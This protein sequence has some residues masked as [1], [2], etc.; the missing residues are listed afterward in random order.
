MMRRARSLNFNAWTISAVVFAAGVLVSATIVLADTASTSVTVG[1]SSPTVS[2]VSMNGGTNITLTE[3]TFVNATT[4]FTVTDGNG[5]STISSVSAQFAFASTSAALYG[6]NCSY[7]AQVCYFPTLCAAT[8]TGNT[9]TGGSD[10]SVQYDCGY[11]IWYPARPTDG[12]SPGLSSAQWYVSATATDA[13]AATGNA[14]NTGE[15]IEVVTLNALNVSGSIGFG[16][17]SANADT[18]G[19]NQSVTHTNTGNTAI[20]NQVSGDVMCTDYSTCVGGVLQ[21]SQQKFGLSDVTYAS[22]TSTLAATTSP[23]SIEFDLATSSAT[24]TAITDL[25][26]WGIAI[27]NGQTTGAYTGQNTFTAVAD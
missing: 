27:P 3:N 14:T 19:T 4:T 10:T 21:P 6:A 13:S 8:T 17:V 16:T 12:S 22:L 1:N 18:G 26:Y 20:D 15:T 25:S 5:C 23:A 24:T 2:A 11:K 9:C 7:N